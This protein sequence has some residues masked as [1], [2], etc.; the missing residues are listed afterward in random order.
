MTVD[1]D[2]GPSSPPHQQLLSFHQ[3]CLRFTE[4]ELSFVEPRDNILRNVIILLPL[5][6]YT[7][8]IHFRIRKYN[9]CY[10]Q[11]VVLT[12]LTNK[13]ISLEL[14]VSYV[15]SRP[16]QQLLGLP[17]LCLSLTENKPTLAEC[18]YNY[19]VFTYINSFIQEN[20]YT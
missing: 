6:V 2:G 11:N 14:N 16:H 7:F 13:W 17:Q 5:C 1:N 19:T 8:I 10:I 4:H 15:G 9:T 3:L 18:S 20:I 12:E